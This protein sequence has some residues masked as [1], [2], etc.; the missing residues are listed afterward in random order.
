MALDKPQPTRPLRDAAVEAKPVEQVGWGLER[1]DTAAEREQDALEA[2]V[3]EQMRE[4]LQPRLEKEL[5]ELR[6]QAQK[7]GYAAGLEAGKRSGYEAGFAQG[8]AEA[9]EKMAAQQAQWHAQ[10]AAL[11]QALQSPLS[12]LDETVADA[13]AEVVVRSVAAFVQTDPRLAHDWLVASLRQVLQVFQ[14]QRAA[15]EI[16]VPR[17]ERDTVQALL[18]DLAE[19]CTVSENPELEAG[20]Y[21]VV[22]DASEVSLNLQAALDEYL[23]QLRGQL[24]HHVKDIS[25][26][27]E[28]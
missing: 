16:Q 23:E 6:T 4:A 8:R 24:T 19:S 25:E 22:Q 12:D 10:A 7:E 15:I 13:L 11:L 14:Q 20:H 5:A 21:R 9:E 1:F 2:H 18:G 28:R 27:P 3:L 26:H 17:G